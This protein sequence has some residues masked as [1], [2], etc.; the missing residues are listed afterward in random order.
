MK[1]NNKRKKQAI[2][3]PVLAVIIL[4]AIIFGWQQLNEQAAPTSESSAGSSYNTESENI[5]SDSS[6][7]NGY[8]SS[9]DNEYIYDG[10]YSEEYAVDVS[11]TTEYVY[12]YFANDNLK[13]QHFKKHGIDMGFAD[14]DEYEKAASD[15]VNNPDALHKLE[16]EDGD[17]VYYVEATN[18]FVVVSTY[19]YIRTYF[20]PDSGIAYYNKQ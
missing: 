18:E 20:L 5:T 2:S 10:D 11:A 16:A 7:D 6:E 4:L 1:K 15:V 9:Y 12:Y 14:A 8:Y 17:D 13:N 3:L 19:G